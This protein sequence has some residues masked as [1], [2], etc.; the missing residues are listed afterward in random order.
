LSLRRH[1]TVEREHH[2]R[3]RTSRARGEELI[4]AG[5]AGRESLEHVRDL[6]LVFD[7]VDSVQ[8]QED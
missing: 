8:F 2:C 6:I 5:L 4:L 1:E 3:S 7:E